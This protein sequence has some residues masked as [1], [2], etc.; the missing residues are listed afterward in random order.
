M[1]Y[2]RIPLVETIFPLFQLRIKSLNLRVAFSGVPCIC[3]SQE[4]SI[5][6]W[7]TQNLTTQVKETTTTL[8][9]VHE[10]YMAIMQHTGWMIPITSIKQIQ[11]E[12]DSLRA[13]G[14][15]EKTELEAENAL[16]LA[17]QRGLVKNLN[18][19]LTEQQEECALLRLQMQVFEPFFLAG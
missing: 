1:R 14:Q 5:V 6:M 7:N 2:C 15:A 3:V 11:A 10:K 4:R 17:E 8:E 18:I 9:S 13:A 19:L 12:L 16:N